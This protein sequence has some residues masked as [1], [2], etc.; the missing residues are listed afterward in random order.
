MH[1]VHQYALE[2]RFKR[3][4]KEVGKLQSDLQLVSK[5]VP[6]EMQHFKLK[7]LV[8]L[9]LFSVHLEHCRQKV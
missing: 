4:M 5:S 6:E 7:R 3:L 1:R 8:Q 9:F 2:L